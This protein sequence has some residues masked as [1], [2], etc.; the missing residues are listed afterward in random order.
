M[1]T[2]NTQ[3]PRSRKTNKKRNFNTISIYSPSVKSKTTTWEDYAVSATPVLYPNVYIPMNNTITGRL[4]L[5]IRF[6]MF[7]VHVTITPSSTDTFNTFR[8][9]FVQARSVTAV[10]GDLPANL[11]DAIDTKRFKVLYDKLIPTYTMGSV[12]PK[13]L[14]VK[15]P[16]GKQVTYYDNGADQYIRNKYMFA[17]FSDSGAIPHP[18]MTGFFREYFTDVVNK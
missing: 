8:F 13:T 15:F 14:D 12:V 7:H 16:V 9:M 2:K 17:F 10:I 1:T 18:T 11:Y 6:L 4:G 3:Q 5:S